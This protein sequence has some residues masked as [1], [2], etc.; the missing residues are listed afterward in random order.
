V[1]PYDGRVI[2]GSVSGT[3]ITFGSAA[4][5][6]DAQPYPSVPAVAS[7]SSTVFALTGLMNDGTRNRYGVIVGTLSG[8]TITITK[9]SQTYYGRDSTTASG[10][11]S[12]CGV[13]STHFVVSYRTGDNTSEDGHYLKAASISGTTITFGTQVSVTSG[14]ANNYSNII[15]LDSTH[16][17]TASSDILACASLSGTDLTVGTNKDFSTGTVISGKLCKIDD[18]HFGILSYS[19]QITNFR[20]LINKGF[21]TG[22]TITISASDNEQ[23]VADN[24][25]VNGLTLGISTRMILYWNNG[26][27]T[28]SVDWAGTVVAQAGFL[29]NMI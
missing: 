13:D 26:G 3:D 6:F 29:Y 9:N 18:T 23:V 25:N 12:I 7:L 21:V 24:V 17:L 22:T 16:I 20:P 28:R 2:C 15:S 27:T 14:W 11:P 8:T 4:V 1:S 19:D 10:S 5:Y